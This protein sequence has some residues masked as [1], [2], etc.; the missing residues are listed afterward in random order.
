M[1]SP[2]RRLDLY[3]A[4]RCATA[5]G[6]A[7]AVITGATY[8]RHVNHAT[9][10]LGLVLL[11]QGF[12]IRWG[13]AEALS[14][15]LAGSLGFDYFF[16]PPRG[17]GLES[18]DHLITLLAFLLTAITTGGLAARASR[19]RK[20]AEQR[21]DDL[22]RLYDLGS[23]L[24]DD[25]HPESVHERITDC[26]VR[27]IEVEGAAFFDLAGDRVWRSG[28]GSGRVSDAVLREVASSGVT[29]VDR[30]S[31][32]S[33]VTIRESGTTAGSL[34]IA[35]TLSSP[36]MLGA[37]A[38]RV[39]LAIAKAKAARQSMEA[40]VARRSENLKSAVLDA[41]AHEIKGP[42]ATVRVSI[43]TLLSKQPGNSSQQLEL[44]RIVD[45]ETER[46]RRRI[47]DAVEVSSRDA[48]EIIPH[49]S[50]NSVKEAVTHAIQGLG[51]L[52][53]GR[54]VEVHIDET[55]PLAL[56]D[57]EMIE[58]VIWQLLDNA[59]KYSP[60]GSPIRVSGEFTGT[61]IVIGVADSGCGIPK[62]DQERIFEKHYR[63]RAGGPEVPGKGLGLPSAKCIMEAHG[64]EI[65]VRSVPGDGSVF[66]ISLP[67]LAEESSEQRQGIERR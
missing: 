11:T 49:K 47:D 15:S 33:V 58:K 64:G 57:G 3:Q 7:V 29:Y 40:E 45:E 48:V 2:I 19:H 10:A 14:A 50:P 63:G 8:L 21:A 16:L 1:S 32:I 12:A 35:G 25:E 6:I 62:D 41:L 60:P 37:V 9:V 26:V 18:P 53:D 46:L 42:L 59:V 17:F 27:I 36:R 38:E 65:W 44:L 52:R 24:R 51:Q 23:A 39:G 54:Q 28:E 61:E 20:E 34:G 55:V 67:V 4:A 43:S 31:T 5:A 56:F 22:R 66:L 30:Q 13:W